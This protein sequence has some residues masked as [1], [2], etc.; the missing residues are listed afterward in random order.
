MMLGELCGRQQC[1]GSGT[2]EDAAKPG[3]MRWVP[4]SHQW[5]TANNTPRG[6]MMRPAAP[7]PA[8]HIG[9]HLDLTESAQP[10]WAATVKVLRLGGGGPHVGQASTGTAICSG[11][12]R[13]LH[14][15]HTYTAIRGGLILSGGTVYNR[16]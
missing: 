2:G 4:L 11:G 16:F 12:W 6:S 14:C 5:P 8:G 7:S 15:S 9:A 1:H 13:R 10:G 3:A